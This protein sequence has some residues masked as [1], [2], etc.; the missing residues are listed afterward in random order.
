MPFHSNTTQ[1]TVVYSSPTWET[2]VV[3]NDITLQGAALSATVGIID[4]FK[5]ALGKY[6]RVIGEVYIYYTSTDADELRLRFQNVDSA[7]AA[8]DTVLTYSIFAANKVTTDAADLANGNLEG[9]TAATT[10]TGTGSTVNIDS[11]TGDSPLSAIIKFSAI[12]TEGKHGTLSF[13]AGGISTGD[14]TYPVLKAGSYIT[15][16]RF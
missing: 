3:E 8:V 12:G 16:K 5:I 15:Y 9:G 13:Q 7:N 11:G 4:P 10:T 14:T 2:K 1:N 6:Q